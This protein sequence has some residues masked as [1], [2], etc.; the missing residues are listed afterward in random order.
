MCNMKKKKYLELKQVAE[1]MAGQSGEIRAEYLLILDK[2]EM[3]GRIEMPFAE[4]VEDSLFAIRI[5]S[6]GNVRI[7]YTYGKEDRIYGIRAY[8]KKTRDIPVNEMAQARKILKLMR[9][10]SMI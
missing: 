10:E 6:A 7:F 5:I 1:F 4:K 2:L 3:E 8:V 9:R